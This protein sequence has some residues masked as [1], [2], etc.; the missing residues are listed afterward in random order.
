MHRWRRATLFGGHLDIQRVLFNLHRRKMPIDVL[1]S[2]ALEYVEASL[3]DEPMAQVMIRTTDWAHIFKG[4]APRRR[5]HR[6]T[7]ERKVEPDPRKDRVAT[8]N[9]RANNFI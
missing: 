1:R 8:T 7:K 9:T 6:I 3:I 5:P 4:C 2:K